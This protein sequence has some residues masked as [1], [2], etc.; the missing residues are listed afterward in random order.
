M[1]PSESPV[2]YGLHPSAEMGFL[3]MSDNLFKIPLGELMFSAHMEVPHYTQYMLFCDVVPDTRTKP[4]YAPT[5]SFVHW[6]TDFLMRCQELDILDTGPCAASS[7]EAFWLVPSPVLS[8]RSAV[9]GVGH[10]AYGFNVRHFSLTTDVSYV[11][12]AVWRVN[13]SLNKRI[14]ITNIGII[15]S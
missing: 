5:H 3:S 11:C 13:H 7:G 14:K 9:M 8:D 4:A 1:L 12:D 2:L 10:Q 6:V 15:L